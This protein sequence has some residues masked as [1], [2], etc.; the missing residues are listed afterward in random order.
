MEDD[1]TGKTRH[2]LCMTQAVKAMYLFPTMGSY[3]RY[4]TFKRLLPNH[5]VRAYMQLPRKPNN[6]ME[7]QF[8]GDA[9]SLEG[10]VFRQMLYEGLL[11]HVYGQACF[12]KVIRKGK[13]FSDREG[14]IWEHV[15]SD[16]LRSGCEYLMAHKEAYMRIDTRGKPLGGQAEAPSNWLIPEFDCLEDAL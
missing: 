11:E 4:R 2:T 3:W 5:L 6:K 12:W 14:Y 15:S 8:V 7:P 13:I 9:R 16:E 1:L 10:T